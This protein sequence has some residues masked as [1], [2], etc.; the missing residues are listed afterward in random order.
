MRLYDYLPSANGY[1]VRTLLA[2]LGLAYELVPVDIFAGESHTADFHANKN[3]DGRI[4]VLE[5]EPGR[6][7]AESNAILSFLAEGTRLMPDDRFARAQVHQWMFFEQNAVEP[8]IG[9]ARF[10]RLTG[11]QPPQSEV[12]RNRVQN[13]ERALSTLER[14]L[15]RHP[16]LV[17]GRYTVADLCLFAYTHLAPEAGVDLAPYP[18]VA[19]WLERVKA[20]PGFL[21][22]VP[23]Y[24]AN[25]R[26]A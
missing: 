5:P 24:S 25:A 12:L 19:A 2:Q 23:P 1:K 20:Q 13:G 22:P 15:V 18:S 9:T 21:G 6:F 17:D 26:V 3:P 4:P 16:F 10:W 14:H 11:R 8:N 7:L